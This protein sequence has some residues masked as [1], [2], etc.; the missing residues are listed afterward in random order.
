[1]V[2]HS[3]VNAGSGEK[4]KAT[5]EDSIDY[6]HMFPI[7]IAVKRFVFIAAVV[8]VGFGLAQLR[9]ENG[10]SRDADVR[11]LFGGDTHFAWGVQDHQKKIGALALIDPL[12][13][14]F[15]R[16]DLRMVNLETAIGRL[17]LPTP[18]KYYVFRS[19]PE[20]LRSLSALGVQAVSVANNHALDYGAEG[21]G[22]TLDHLK[23]VGIE[24]VGAGTSL[25]A[26]VEPAVFMVK[27]LPVALFAANEI[28]ETGM[29]G[30]GKFVLANAGSL[31]PRIQDVRDSGVIVI[32][33]IHWGL[34]YGT[35]PT[36]DQIKL[37]RKLIDNGAAAVI[38]HHPH[39]PQ[40][41]EIYHNGIIC[42]SL[43]N[44]IFGSQTYMQRDNFLA[45]LNF[46]SEK[47][48]LMSL[49]VHPVSGRFRRTGHVVRPLGGS[50]A[51]EFWNDFRVQTGALNEKMPL[52]EV[53]GTSALI[54]IVLD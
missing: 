45:E 34:E 35:A 52:M 46:S 21:L 10:E 53:N 6:V 49:R 11:M 15:Q 38:G 32:V 13:T 29:N 19:E 24:S 2:P 14:L 12:G 28:V 1:M 48:R 31:I 51:D 50:E 16:A 7:P 20:S 42:Y 33:N 40:G 5:D 36:Q 27:G 30:G 26:A 3:D 4:E 43:G 8:A 39:V 47:R 22:E 17:A 9:A 25:D 44:F 23:R 37:A 54:K 41:I 18:G